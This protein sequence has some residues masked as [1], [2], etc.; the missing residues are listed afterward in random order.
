[1]PV[2]EGKAIGVMGWI[3]LNLNLIKLIASFRKDHLLKQYW[4]SKKS[5]RRDRPRLSFDLQLVSL[6]P[7]KVRSQF[8]KLPF[9][10]FLKILTSVDVRKSIV[11]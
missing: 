9:V 6:S 7:W 10:K 3:Q 4:S 8:E 1:M 11:A 2:Y 5:K